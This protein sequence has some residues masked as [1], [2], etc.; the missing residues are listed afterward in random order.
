MTNFRAPDLDSMVAQLRSAG[1][2]V[3]VDPK[4]H[5]NGRF[6]RLKD[7]AG[8]PMELWQPAGRDATGRQAPSKEAG[9]A[10]K[11]RHLASGR[12]A[13]PMSASWLA[14]NALSH[15]KAASVKP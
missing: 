2:R 13:T 5:P 14:M 8:N 10:L 3:R 1:I 9:Q 11:L 7:P 15:Q 6:A 4:R 12:L